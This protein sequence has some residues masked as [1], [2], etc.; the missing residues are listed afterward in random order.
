MRRL[1][2][3]ACFFVMA[4]ILTIGAAAAADRSV[5]LLK[6]QD[7]PGFD[8]QTDKNATLPQCQQACVDDKLCMAFTYNSKAKWCFLKSDV[9]KPNAF[10]GATSGTINLTPSPADLEK[11]RTSDLPFPP[12]DLIASAKDFATNLPTTDAPPKDLTYPDLVKAGDEGVAQQNPAAAVVSYRQ[13][14]A[15]NHNDPA[16]WLKLTNV[17]LTQA[18]DDFTK[19]NTIQMY[20]EG[21]TASYA[22]LNGFLRSTE[23]NQRAALLA[24]LAHALERR[25]MWRESILTYRTSLALVDSADI[26]ARLDD[27]VAQHG[28]RI[29]DNQVDAEAADPRICVTFSDPLPLTGTDMSNY[30]VVEGV[31]K[32]SVDTEQTQICVTG[33]EH[34]KRYHLTFRAGLPS[35]DNEA[36]KKDVELNLYVP[37]RTPFVGFANNAYVLPAGLGGGLPITS[38]NAQTADVIIYRIGDRDD[39]CVN[40]GFVNK[41]GDFDLFSYDLYRHFRDNTSEFEQLAAFQ[42]G[43]SR[44]NVRRAG[45][46]ARAERS[47]YVSGNYFTTFGVGVARSNFNKRGRTFP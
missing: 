21:A 19:Q 27:D 14:L 24:V 45:G 17:V 43:R 25:E 34:G 1:V 22:A 3:S 35:A 36:L 37:D 10:V 30:V 13:A 20:D 32:I 38:V 23:V 6:D 46:T 16:L 41:D 2:Q 39:C 8:Y 5:T 7:L 9:G 18:D 29:T 11:Q 26:Q 4:A 44:M 47:E 12:D 42:S 33:I 40:G 15:L 31:S 28:F